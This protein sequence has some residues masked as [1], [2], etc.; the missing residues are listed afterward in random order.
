MANG[1]DK[2][3][4]DL[5]TLAKERDF[6]RRLLALNGQEELEPLLT[7]ALQLIVEVTGAEVAY[8]ELR[9]ATDE[10]AHP[11]FWK[12]HGASAEEIDEIRRSISSGIIARTLLEGRT[13]MTASALDDERFHDL[14]SVRSQEIQ[15]VLCAPVSADPSI[16]V[17]YLQGDRLDGF[18]EEDRERAE[19]FARQLAPLADRLLARAPSIEIADPTKAIRAR[20]AC[21]GLIGRSPALAY[22]L[23][24]AALVAPL[25]IDVLITGPA[26]T[27]KTALAKT[28][29]D[30]SG[31]RH[32]PFLAVN[33]AAIPDTLIESELFGYEKGSHS[34]ADKRKAGVVEASEGGTLFLDEVGELS[35]GAQAKLLQLLQEREYRPLGATKPVRANI[36]VISATNADLRRRVADRLFREDLYY[37]L[38]VMP[39]AMPSLAERRE[40]IPVLVEYLCEAACRRHGFEKMIVSRRAALACR[41][42]SW[43]GQVR[44]LSHAIESSVI[45]ARAEGSMTVQPEHVF[46]PA[47]SKAA[48]ATAAPPGFHEATRAFHR[49]FLL[50]ALEHSDWNVTKTAERIELSRAQVYNLIN[51]LGIRDDR[52]S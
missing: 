45:R 39:V 17:V 22:V 44:E 38:H 14:G 33:C 31:R 21:D 1:S 15:A 18:S 48:A 51:S 23:Q 26:G 50:D 24:Q 13:V 47:A 27:G 37:R 30:N 4:T 9:D 29:A 2:A 11:R 41:E 5:A 40:D 36:R 49:S 43:P 52:R 8:L 28:I 19:G 3:P 35:I 12:G 20:F 6:Y 7:Q 46:P 42:A 25:D 10:E 16:G 34:G 32:G